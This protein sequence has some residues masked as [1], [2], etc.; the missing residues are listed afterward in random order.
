MNMDRIILIKQ[1]GIHINS[2]VN[3]KCRSPLLVAGAF[4]VLYHRIF[5]F[6]LVG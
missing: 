3:K 4:F 6:A 5:Q 1:N 2:L